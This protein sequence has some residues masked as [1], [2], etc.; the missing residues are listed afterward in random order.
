MKSLLKVQAGWRGTELAFWQLSVLR[1]TFR[2]VRHRKS[3]VAETSQLDVATIPQSARVTEI[4]TH[5]QTSD[6]GEEDRDGQVCPCQPPDRIFYG[7]IFPR[8]WDERVGR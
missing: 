5:L 8:T 2:P 4:T 6:S 7:L 1:R 3:T